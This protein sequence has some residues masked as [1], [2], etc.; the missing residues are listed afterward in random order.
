MVDGVC[1]WTYGVLI[2]HLQAEMVDAKPGRSMFTLVDLALRRQKDLIAEAR[3]P[4]HCTS[5]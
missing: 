3:V 1:A 4:Q 2:L 5:S